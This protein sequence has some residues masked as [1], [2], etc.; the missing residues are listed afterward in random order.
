M[1]A[2]LRGMTEQ[3]A[4]SIVLPGLLV[5]VGLLGVI[6]PVIPGLIVAL[7]GVL[8][9]ALDLSTTAGWVVFGLCVAIYGCGLVAQFLIPGKRMKAAGISNLTLFLG[10]A[11]GIIGFFVVGTGDFGSGFDAFKHRINTVRAIVHPQISGNPL[12]HFQGGTKATRGHFLVNVLMLFR[13]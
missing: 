8:I 2:L 9:W 7:I 4:A 3:P 6:I 11:V 5:I 13:G 1:T 10:V 12:A